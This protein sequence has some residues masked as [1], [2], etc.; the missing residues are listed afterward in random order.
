MKYSAIMVLLLVFIGSAQ[1]F[2]SDVIDHP[3]AESILSIQDRNIVEGY[4]DGTFRPDQGITRAEI[5]KIVLEAK[6]PANWVA[7]DHVFDCFPDATD[8][9]Y[10]IYVCYAKQNDIV[11]W[12]PDGMFKAGQEVTVAEWLK[13]ALETF[14]LPVQEQEWRYWYSSYMDFV[15]NN[16]IFSRYALNPDRSITRGEVAH[17]VNTLMHMQEGS[18]AMD[19]QR[20]NFSAWCLMPQEPSS[21]PYTSMVD[22][23][24]REYI[25]TIGRQYDHSTPTKLIIAFHGRTNSNEDIQWYYNIDRVRDEEGIIVYP[26]WLP[27]GNGRGRSDAWDPNNDLR[28][29][30]FFDQLVEEFGK[31]YCIDMDEIYVVWHSLGAWFT[32]TLACARGDVIRG[33]GSV[34]WSITPNSCSGPV[35]TM[36]MHNPN[37]RLAS[38]AGWEHARDQFLA[39]NHCSPD[40]YEEIIGPENA[41]CVLYTDCLE[42]APVVWCPHTQDYGWGSYYPHNRPDFAAEQIWSFFQS[43]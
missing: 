18:I 37:D 22:G 12:Y 11:K 26:A 13:I 25:T 20:Q 34:G 14:A 3:Y 10:A 33:I 16:N 28:D 23:I 24:Q 6:I 42:D 31:N 27:N 2:F 43:L 7:I 5:L 40:V 35:A 8:Q 41:N 36:I 29:F 38:F 30:A 17:L 21:V 32:N 19:H 39:Q 15:H 1:A 4:P 9:W